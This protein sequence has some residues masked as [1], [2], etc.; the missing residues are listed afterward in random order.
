MDNISRIFVLYFSK[1]AIIVGPEITLHKL[2]HWL[3]IHQKL[4]QTLSGVLR[5]KT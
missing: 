4:L 3:L 5:V 1:Q 2:A